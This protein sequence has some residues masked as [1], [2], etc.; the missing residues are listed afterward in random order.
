MSD[1]PA[2]V[3]E[4][5]SPSAESE[6]ALPRSSAGLMYEPGG[7]SAFAHFEWR[8]RVLIQNFEREV[9][10]FRI[11]PMFGEAGDETMEDRDKRLLAYRSRGLAPREIMLIDPA[12]GGVAAIMKAYGRID[13]KNKGL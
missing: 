11:R 8:I 5:Q 3:L 2:A 6:A 13:S 1:A 10:S 9:D 12:Q 7:E 4:R